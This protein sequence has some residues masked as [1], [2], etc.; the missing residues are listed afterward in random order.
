[1]KN[2]AV[3][4]EGGKLES[5]FIH[6]DLGL[7]SP[8]NMGKPLVRGKKDFSH[9][10]SSCNRDDVDFLIPQPCTNHV[11]KSRDS[12]ECFFSETSKANG[13]RSCQCRPIDKSEISDNSESDDGCQMTSCSLNKLQVV[14][15]ADVA[16][17]VPL[18]SDNHH[19]GVRIKSDICQDEN[20]TQVMRTITSDDMSESVALEKALFSPRTKQLHIIAV[21]SETVDAS[22]EIHT[23]NG[24]RGLECIEEGTENAD[25]DE[26]NNRDVHMDALSC[27]S[28]R[29]S[30][31][32][33]ATS[34]SL[35]R[36]DAS[37][38]SSISSLSTNA[39]SCT[40]AAVSV[41]G[42]DNRVTL[43]DTEDVARNCQD[44]S[45]NYNNNLV[46]HDKEVENGAKPKR[47][48][49]T[50]FLTRNLF[51]W[52]AKD[53]PP[54]MPP[55]SS[56]SWGLF[57][58]ETPTSENIKAVEIDQVENAS[59]SKLEKLKSSQNNF[60]L[61]KH[62]TNFL[63][64]PSSTTALILENRPINLPAKS[65]EEEQ[66]HRHQYEQMIE[67]VKKKE[68]KE[69]KLRKRLHEQQ[70]KN[71]ELIVQAS[72]IW[73]I[74]I[75]PNWETMKS[76]RRTKELW[77]LGIPPSV[78]GKVWKLAIGNDLNITSELYE[79]CVNRAQH[80]IRMA[81]ESGSMSE[82]ECDDS[83]PDK[84]SSVELIKLDVART[85]PLLCIFQK[86]GPYYDLL[87]SLLGA[88]VCYRP[89]IGYLQGMSFLAAVLI[90]NLDVADAFICFANLLNKPCQLAF[91][92]LIEPMMKSY[93]TTYEEFFM[94]N[95]PKLF[96]HFKKHKVEPDLY[97]IDWIYTLYSKSLPL[98][99]ASR[100]WDV[101][102]RDGE[103][104]LFQTALGILYLHEELLLNMDF[105]HIVQFLTKLPDD[106]SGISLFD[107]IELVRMSIDKKHF[108]QVL[109]FHSD[110]SDT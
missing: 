52:K 78:R 47:K 34:A 43:T 21:D 110:P 39:D 25:G 13:I 69:A 70:L 79:I 65:L 74:E 18:I 58:K 44:Q 36:T 41:S 38:F 15:T 106:I 48:G 23:F 56:P 100:V 66:K 93:F 68:L 103:E 101:F 19:R 5:C 102:Y 95:L 89:D 85:F 107:S 42:E 9:E 31:P 87:H 86:G 63:F 1:M 49:I 37:S 98:D 17:I 55:V 40:T 84:E 96:R 83:S 16:K 7:K 92:R 72:K 109:T 24:C 53:T 60:R 77:W 12:K 11:W 26:E 61:P 10:F 46:I 45:V 2:I 62:K 6:P 54:S 51:S 80:R 91:F 97:L 73:N 33:G 71:E 4:L 8:S 27:E 76:S 90:L 35:S 105:I 3:D 108:N 75:L 81:S 28:L 29:N 94:E 50:D 59:T 104:F 82:E 99:V 20:I 67:A 32:R 14:C 88:Y 30:L 64:N 22:E 57:S